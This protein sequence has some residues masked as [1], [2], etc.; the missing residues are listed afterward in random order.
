MSGRS[1]GVRDGLVVV[2]QFLAAAGRAIGFEQ[3]LT[4]GG[5]DLVVVG[6]DF[7]KRQEAV[8]IAA[9]FDEARLQRGFDPRYLR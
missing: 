5:G 8:P 7:R 6:M 4:I 2:F 1:T 3:R 9:V